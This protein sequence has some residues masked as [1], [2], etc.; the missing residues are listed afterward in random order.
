[1]RL[2]PDEYVSD[3]RL[4]IPTVLERSP[5]PRSFDQL[6][7]SYGHG[8][9]FGGLEKVSALSA[10]PGRRLWR[11]WIGIINSQTG[12]QGSMQQCDFIHKTGERLN[13]CMHT[14]NCAY[15]NGAFE[16]KTTNFHIDRQLRVL[17]KLMWS[18]YPKNRLALEDQ[19]PSPLKWASILKSTSV[20]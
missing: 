11:W 7:L 15:L 2:A 16:K 13:F 19:W 10:V 20:A 4:G 1:M 6:P 12:I 5:S 17:G 14:L 3:R 9:G 18:V 8:Q